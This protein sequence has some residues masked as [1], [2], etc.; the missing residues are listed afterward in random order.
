MVNAAYLATEIAQMI[1][2]KEIPAE[3]EGREGFYHLIDMKGDIAHAEITYILRDHDKDCFE[4][5]KKVMQE[6]CDKISAKYPTAKV[7]CEIKDS[8]ANMIEIMNAHPDIVK[9]AKE[10]IEAQGLTPISR[11][12]RGGTDGAQ[13]SFM[14]LPCPNLGTGGYGFHGP[15]EHV[16]LE[17]IETVVKELIYIGKN[18]L[19]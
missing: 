2:K 15:F 9:L 14:G 6:F 13:L 7:S 10:A 1:P 16:T 17:G 18:P 5:R 3:T 8:Y 12:I 19:K 4:E 11:P